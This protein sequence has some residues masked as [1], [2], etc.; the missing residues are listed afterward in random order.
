MKKF[1]QAALKTLENAL[2]DFSYTHYTEAA[3]W[4]TSTV[5]RF[6]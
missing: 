5:N 1:I 4:T 6:E 3:M 2:I